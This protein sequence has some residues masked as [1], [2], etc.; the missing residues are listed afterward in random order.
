MCPFLEKEGGYL[1]GWDESGT[2]LENRGAHPPRPNWGPGSGLR[3]VQAGH[4]LGNGL[5]FGRRQLKGDAGHD[6]AII[7]ALARLE[8]Q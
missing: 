3:L 7:G 4:V 8:G 2:T 5:D 6:V 1:G